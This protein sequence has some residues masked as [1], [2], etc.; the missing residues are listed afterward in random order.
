MSYQFKS[1]HKKLYN[2]DAKIVIEIN[3]KQ[4]ILT[5]SQRTEVE[6]MYRK[7]MTKSAIADIFGCHYTT[8][9]RILRQRNIPIREK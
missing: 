3:V 2:E 4:T 5:E 8:I 1:A 9:G 7:G 6:I